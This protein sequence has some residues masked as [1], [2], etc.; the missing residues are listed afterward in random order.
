ML[1]GPYATIIGGGAPFP[2]WSK[3]SEVRFTLD[4][5]RSGR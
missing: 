1:S 5:P 4:L 2:F 3:W